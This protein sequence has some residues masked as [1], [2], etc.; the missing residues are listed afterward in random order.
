MVATGLAVVLFTFALALGDALKD[1]V[2]LLAGGQ[3]TFRAFALLV[4]STIPIVIPNAL[5]LGLL[6][7][8]LV[9]LG[10]M[11]ANN[12]ILALKA[13][14]VSLYRIVSS[15]I[16]LAALG[17]V[18]AST[19][20]SYYAPI[21]KRNYETI[22]KS[23]IKEEPRR[24]LQART[25][26]REFPGFVIYADTQNANELRGLHIWE[27]SP[28]KQVVREIHAERGFINYDK[29]TNT[30]QL[31]LQKTV[32][33][34]KRP[35]DPENFIHNRLLIMNSDEFPISLSLESILA[36]PKMSGKLSLMTLTQLLEE[37][38]R[39]LATR[40]DNP[41]EQAAQQQDLM[42]IRMAIQKNFARS[43]AVIALCLIALPLGIKISRSETYA[44]LAI[45]LLLAMTY[46]VLF[47]MFMW[48]ERNPGIRPD[49]WIW[50]PNVLFLSAGLLALRRAN[51]DGM[52]PTKA[53]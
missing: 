11:S 48:L 32:I 26:I 29:S 38:S 12:E 4:V 6:T 45:A 7:A 42:H 2:D 51:Y 1:I 31:N 18:L 34:L 53:S 52:A 47:I 44:N 50:L 23:I 5:P 43:F 49:L 36:N 37:K 14:G 16:V 17:S 15:I 25:F 19:V 24:F 30:I 46:Y 13:A 33:Q 22:I 8:V 35:D 40:T 39:L 41:V 3:L 21:A 20:A 9:V 28:Q 27:L 10:R